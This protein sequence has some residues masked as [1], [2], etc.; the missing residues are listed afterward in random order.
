RYARDARRRGETYGRQAVGYADENR[1]TT[2]IAFA[3]VA[4]AAGWLLRPTR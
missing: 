3:A 4:F 1:A 2:L